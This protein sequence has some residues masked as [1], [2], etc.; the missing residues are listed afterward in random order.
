MGQALSML[1]GP[2][3]TTLESETEAT[4]LCEVAARCGGCPRIFESSH[5]QH[6][7]K[8]ERVLAL[9]AERS[10]VVPHP[11]QW[12]D[13]P[14]VGYRN[15]IRLAVVEGVPRF[16]NAQKA[17]GCAVLEPG[18]Q[19]S[20]NAFRAWAMA[21]RKPLEAFRVAEVRAPDADAKAAVYLRHTERNGAPRPAPER[22]QVPNT[23]PLG[24]VA[25]E[26]GPVEYQRVY[27]TPD[28]W[29]WSPV[30]GFGQ[31]NT[32]VNQRM[33]Q[34]V[35]R[36]LCASGT[37]TFLDLFAGSGNFA[38]ALCASG[39]VGAA[40]EADATACRA[41]ERSL[42]SH[43][44]EELDVRCGDA[45]T[46]AHALLVEGKRFDAVVLDPPRRGLRG[47]VEAVVRLAKRDI[48]LVSCNAEQFAIDAAALC[49]N[50]FRVA[51]YRL[52]D[53]FPN[54]EHIELVAHFVR[55]D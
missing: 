15:R 19:V 14:R 36:W 48:V 23:F 12:L 10:V 22:S 39:M 51:D 20:V 26:Q 8:A 9:L 21:Y 35:V 42:H 41:L 1:V 2:V 31:I 46:S 54:T 29:L 52:V 40:V 53:M 25:F 47:N 33:V 24:C 5:A 45:L 38:L 28:V 43:G 7:A 32:V 55:D 49:A 13:G 18:L 11:V 3:V 34:T 44:L 30:G 4:A 37:R 6:E 16:F 50:G 17:G 27:C